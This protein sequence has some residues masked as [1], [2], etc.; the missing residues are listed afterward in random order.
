MLIELSI[1]HGL[2][3]IAEGRCLGGTHNLFL[4]QVVQAAAGDGLIRHPIPIDQQALLFVQREQWQPANR[5]IRLLEQGI[6][7]MLE[8]ISHAGHCGRAK[9]I[10]A[11]TEPAAERTVPC[12]RLLLFAHDEQEINRQRNRGQGDP[13]NRQ[14]GQIQTFGQPILPDKHRLKE[15]VEI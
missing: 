1:T 11:V 13:F 9:E 8:M 12:A 10:G 6:E 7:Q 4:K 2:R 15:G 3:A 5:H 14:V